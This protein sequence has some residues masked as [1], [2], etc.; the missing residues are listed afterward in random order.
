MSSCVDANIILSKKELGRNYSYKAEN[1]VLMLGGIGFHDVER[2][3]PIVLING[4]EIEYAQF[5]KI[6]DSKRNSLNEK[7]HFYFEGE[8]A[9]ALYGEK[10][11]SGLHYF[12]DNN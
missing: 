7:S 9:V 12:I 5:E 1:E 10:A 11:K 2:V 4:N 6:L 8:A 3:D